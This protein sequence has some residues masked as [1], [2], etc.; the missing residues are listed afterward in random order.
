MRGRKPVFLQLVQHPDQQ[1]NS[2][3]PDSQS[4][5]GLSQLEL[6]VNSGPGFLR[7]V[8][9]DLVKWQFSCFLMSYCEKGL[10]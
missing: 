6:L 7:T 4:D 9:Q 1:L 8:L 10:F 2:Q 5:I 3:P